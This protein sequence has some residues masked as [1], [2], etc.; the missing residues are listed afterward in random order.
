MH[1][2]EYDKLWG[3]S[4]RVVTLFFGSL[5]HPCSMSGR[6]DKLFRQNGSSADVLLTIAS[7]SH[8]DLERN[9]NFGILKKLRP[10]AK[11]D[12]PQAHVLP[13]GSDCPRRPR[14]PRCWKVDHTPRPIEA[15]RMIGRITPLL[16]QPFS[17]WLTLIKTRSSWFNCALRDDEAVYWVS[18]EPYEGLAVGTWWYWVSRGHLCLYI[19]H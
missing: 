16:S 6:Y 5:D 1:I 11:A 18:I 10:P 9:E 13:Q 15:E 3:P 12:L 7:E 14:S 19:L 4:Q 17:L 2:F 8:K